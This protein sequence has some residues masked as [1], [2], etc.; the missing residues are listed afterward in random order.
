MEDFMRKDRA[1]HTVL[2]LSKFGLMQI[3]RERTRPE[4]TLNTAEDCPACGGTGTINSTIL[5]TDD[6]ER[7]LQF[8]L[9]SRPKSDIQLYVHPYVDAY[10]KKGWIFSSIRMKWFWTYKKW[11]KIT[12]DADCHINQYRFY[13]GSGDEI[14]MN[15]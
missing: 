2:P 9:Q 3:T 8:I 15:G 5:L 11:I 1:Q 4:I 6:I 7:D 10:L 12:P 13:D 14:R